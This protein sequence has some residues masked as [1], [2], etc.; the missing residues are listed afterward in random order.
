[1]TRHRP[2][3]LLGLVAALAA[4][5]PA[6]AAPPGI[7]ESV[8]GDVVTFA[9]NP[10]TGALPMPASETWTGPPL[11]LS[12][13]PETVRAPGILYQ[14]DVNGAF[15]LFFDHVD[16]DAESPTLTIGVLVTNPGDAP[17][18]LRLGRVGTAGPS[19]DYFA[20]GQAAERAWMTSSPGPTLTVAPGA[21]AF[22]LPALEASPATL[23]QDVTGIVDGTSSGQL[24]I[25]VVA[26]ED[27]EPSLAGLQVEPARRQAATGFAMRGTFP[28]SELR[29]T[30]LADGA[31][32]KLDMGTPRDYLQGYSAVDG[33][34]TAEDY[35]NYGVLYDVR[36]DAMGQAGDLALVLD[37]QGGPFAGAGLLG[38]GY[39]P[40]AEIDLPAGGTFAPDPLGSILVGRF[41]LQQD[42]TLLLHFEW[43]PPAGSFLPTTL[44]L[45]PY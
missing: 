27:P 10:D 35:G 11:L 34:A 13:A 37:P 22:L 38:T 20:T 30:A 40:P 23:G 3:W 4:A 17:A 18:S 12:D 1:M 33:L 15:R 19:P 5:A 21:T 36:V 39:L 26:Q 42:T 9:A 16:G 14:D 31:L 28:H 6:S 43:M 44:V 45:S 29:I 8:P 32:Q 7:A 41:A 24:Q 25:S 2:L